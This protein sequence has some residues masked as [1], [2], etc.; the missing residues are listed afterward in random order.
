MKTDS[1]SA[2]TSGFT[3]SNR[4]YKDFFK[5]LRG[6]YTK[7]YAARLPKE[8]PV[9]LISGLDDPVGNMG[10]GVKK[11]AAYYRKQGMKNLRMVLFENSRHEF[12]NE[13]DR[14]EEKWNAVLSFF[15]KV[16]DERV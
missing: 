7:E 8:L 6:L 2:T 1:G 3:C 13:R 15:D 5:G 11:L 10:K 12:L 4:F 9:L 16:F 14:R